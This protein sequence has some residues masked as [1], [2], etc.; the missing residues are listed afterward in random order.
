MT[1]A[2]MIVLV[3]VF[4]VN[5]VSR[6]LLLSA[7]VLA[8]GL[9]ANGEYWRL[10]TYGFTSVGLLGLG[11]NLLVLWLAGRA[12]ESMIGGWRL[13]ALYVLA[14]L[15]GATVLFVL[16][17]FDLVAVGAPSAVVGLLAAHGVLKL[18]AR[19]DVRTDIGL[20]VLIVLYSVLVGFRTLGW[21]GLLGGM[22]VGA[23]AG[24]VI[25]YAPRQSRA[26]MQTFGLLGIGIVCVLAVAAQLVI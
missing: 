12:L 15:G 24:V 13:L 22:L 23:L 20:L 8:N 3:A 2:L 18:R 7:M 17:P 6:G 9:V 4:V 1:I 26:L 19:E 21:L 11:M 14:G 16:G 5:F 25:A 10:L